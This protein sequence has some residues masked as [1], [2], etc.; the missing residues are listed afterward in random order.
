MSIKMVAID[1]DGTLLNEEKEITKEAEMAVA[2]AVAAGIEVVIA[3]GRSFVEFQ[4]LLPQLHGVRYAATCAGALVMELASQTILRSGSMPLDVTQ[5]FY[6]LLADEPMMFEV[7]SDG[8]VYVQRDRLENNAY[9][10]QFSRNPI[11]PNSRTP[12]E[13]MES[14]LKTLETPVEKVHI[15]YYDNDTRNAGWDKIRHLP[16]TIAT[17][18]PVDLDVS[19]VDINKGVAVKFLAERLGF[20]A[21][22]ILALGDSAND[23]D[24]FRY[25]GTSVAMGNAVPELKEIATM[26][27]VSND[28]NGVAKVLNGLLDGSL[29]L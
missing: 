18:E 20:Q 21:D 15:Y 8:Y 7:F 12:V 17:T 6:R 24:M 26:V 4:P 2:K 25:V 1:M 13:N 16:L 23:M 29:P 27:T 9:Y 28:D 19:P 10:T 3:T 14:F 5:E 22:Q 11:P